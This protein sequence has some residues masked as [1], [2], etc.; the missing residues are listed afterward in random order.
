MDTSVDLTDTLDRVRR[1]L[2]Q[3]PHNS[4]QVL[5]RV[6]ARRIS[7]R[8]LENENLHLSRPSVI[9]HTSTPLRSLD[10]S[11]S[12]VPSVPL[13]RP[14]PLLNVL[15]AYLTEENSHLDT[16]VELVFP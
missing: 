14:L 11:L 3:T 4:S 2:D 8:K 9:I 15:E 10:N 12:S 1:T 13:D 6:L 7:A 5:D 16:E